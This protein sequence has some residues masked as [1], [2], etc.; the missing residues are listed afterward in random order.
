M[1]KQ[2]RI[3]K[4]VEPVWYCDYIGEIFTVTTEIEADWAAEYTY[5]VIQNGVLI[6][7]YI[8]DSDCVDLRCEKIKRILYD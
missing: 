1:I 6:G 7:S 8:K 5:Q 3:I 4:G 2:V